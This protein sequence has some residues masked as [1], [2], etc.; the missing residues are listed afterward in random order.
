MLQ[1]SLSQRQINMR[2]GCI[3]MFF[4]YTHKK[5]SKNQP[6]KTY[7]KH[8][9]LPKNFAVAAVAPLKGFSRIVR[10]FL[11][12]LDYCIKATTLRQIRYHRPY[13]MVIY[14]YLP[15][16]K[17]PLNPQRTGTHVI[18]I[19]IRCNESLTSYCTCLEI[20]IPHNIFPFVVR[21]LGI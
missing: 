12:E 6:L 18:D 11:A 9:V 20:R 13:R 4:K 16:I 21:H 7:S 10:Q 19:P 2:S 1:S 15:T 8:Q 3:F 5:I 14:A 17:Q